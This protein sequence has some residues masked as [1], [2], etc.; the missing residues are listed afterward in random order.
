[1]CYQHLGYHNSHMAP[2]LVFHSEVATHYLPILTP[3]TIVTFL[4]QTFHS[5][6]AYNLSLVHII[7]S[8]NPKFLGKA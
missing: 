1:M 6:S 2:F 3:A 4:K 5:L 8:I 7:R